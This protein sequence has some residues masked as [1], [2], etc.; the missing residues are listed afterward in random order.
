[1]PI[2]SIL[3]DDDFGSTLDNINGGLECPAEDN[4]WHATAVQLR[5]NRYCRAASA[6]GVER[7]SSLNG[8]VDMDQRMRQ[9]LDEKT[10]DD[11]KAWEDT[12]DLPEEVSDDDARTT[13]GDDAM[14][15]SH[16]GCGKRAKAGKQGTLTSS[17]GGSTE[18]VDSENRS[19][20]RAKSSKQAMD[21]LLSMSMRPDHP[22]EF[23]PSP[24]SA[25]T[26]NEPT[27]SISSI[28]TGSSST[29]YSTLSITTI[30]DPTSIRVIATCNSDVECFA[31]VRSSHP[32]TQKSIV[33][34][35]LC[36]CYAASSITPFDEC[37][38][39]AT[40]VTAKCTN[41]CDGFEGYCDIEIYTGDG[42]R[43]C[44]L[45][46]ASTV[47]STISSTT[48]TTPTKPNSDDALTSMP[49]KAATM[50]ITSLRGPEI[51]PPTLSL[52]SSTIPLW[53]VHEPLNNPPPMS[54]PNIG[55]KSIFRLYARGGIV[56]SADCS[57]E[58][59]T[60]G[61]WAR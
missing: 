7:L 25:V 58:F 49:T 42:V 8:C 31:T 19:V 27:S 26:S 11:C 37:E 16:V 32:R 57:F 4:G 10:C 15:M 13:A 36:Q 38:D 46:P 40:C 17:S 43:D 55:G 18:V 23:S 33:G 2:Q 59:N 35:E 56:R 51:N 34:I 6:I 1:M 9:C 3:L 48:G 50:M 21:A 28:A 44:K 12:L 14:S 60:K 41:A 30:S 47:V 5:L 24:T 61:E 45:R 52:D 20:G 54:A 22:S 39:D 53:K 29:M